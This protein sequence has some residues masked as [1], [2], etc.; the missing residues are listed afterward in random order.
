MLIKYRWLF[1]TLA[2]VLAC[3]AYFCAKALY[4]DWELRNEASVAGYQ[5]K[6]FKT[7]ASI[8]PREFMARDADRG[9]YRIFDKN[10]RKVYEIFS[11]SLNF[12]IVISSEEGVEFQLDSGTHTW[13][14]PKK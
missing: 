5:V 6:S 7:V 13:T 4:F 10:G 3:A 9:Y 8:D 1:G 11:D 12:D 2:V 14:L